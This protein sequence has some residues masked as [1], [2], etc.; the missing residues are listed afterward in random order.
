MPASTGRANLSHTCIVLNHMHDV[1]SLSSASCMRAEGLISRPSP[2]GDAQCARRLSVPLQFNSAVQ[3]IAVFRCVAALYVP[4]RL[5]LVG[6]AADGEWLAGGRKGWLPTVK[7]AISYRDYDRD[8]CFLGQLTV[9]WRLCGRL[10]H[11]V[12]RRFRSRGRRR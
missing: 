6:G 11:G 9:G 5:A 3:I 7:S 2:P 8:R 4:F 1:S 12:A 10:L